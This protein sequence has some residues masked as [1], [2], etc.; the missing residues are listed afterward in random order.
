M[1]VGSKKACEEEIDKINIYTVKE[2]SAK[3][4]KKNSNSD[5]TNQ[6]DKDI[7]NHEITCLKKT[8]SDL[9]DENTNLKAL[10]EELKQ[11]KSNT[12]SSEPIEIS[13]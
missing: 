10:I 6:D 9:E 7:L 5:K 11:S 2:K 8:L 4:D 3:N 12:N 13:K 1:L